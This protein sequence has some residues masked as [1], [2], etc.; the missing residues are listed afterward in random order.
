MRAAPLAIVAMVITF[1]PEH[2][3]TLG[4][5]ALGGVALVSAAI[6]IVG[7][8]RG[9]YPRAAFVGLGVAFAVGGAA[10]LAAASTGIATLLFVSSAVFAVTGIVELAAGLRGRGRHAGAKDWI[11]VGAVG[12]LLAL[13]TLLIP[14]DYSQPMTIPGKEIPPLTAS[15][16]VV[17]LLG[18]YCAIA[19]VYLAIAGLSLKWAKDPIPVESE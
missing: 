15:V 19:A 6:V 7:A 16:I 14:S 18:A 11:F 13:V 10:S 8:L 3:T 9:A 2:S 17:G 5:V 1:T 4:F 12:A